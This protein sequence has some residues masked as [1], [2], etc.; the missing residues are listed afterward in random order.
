MRALPSS[1]WRR[2]APNMACAAIVFFSAGSA[3][4]RVAGGHLPF[5][6]FPIQ[7]PSDKQKNSPPTI[8]WDEQQP[9]CTLSRGDDGKYYWGMWSGDIGV[10]LGVDAREMQIIRHRIEPIFSILL[11]IRYRGVGT[12]DTGP[13]GITLQFVKHFK[14]EQPSLDPADY[15]QKVQ[16]DA[17]AFDDETRR[18]IRK[19][20][21]EKPALEKRLQDYQKSITELIEFLNT[22]GLRVSSLDRANPEVRGW[23]FFD[24]K[25][26]WLGGWKS[27]EEFLLRIPLAGKIFEFPFKLPPEKGKFL[28]QKRP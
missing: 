6:S 7:S 10:I 14:V 27:E 17:D 3:S 16:A 5:H 1:V 19:H 2:L 22:N 26:K 25:S 13:S 11:T 8:R 20:P 24:T 21:E 9:G 12:L 28:L 4:A 23:I 18:S 15:I